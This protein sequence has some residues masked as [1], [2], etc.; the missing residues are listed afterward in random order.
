[1]V[2]SSYDAGGRRGW[3]IRLRS[4][5]GAFPS[6]HR[7]ASRPM[8]IAAWGQ[9]YAVILGNVLGGDFREVDPDCLLGA[10]AGL[11]HVLHYPV[12]HSAFLLVGPSVPAS[13][14]MTQALFR[15]F[16]LDPVAAL[17]NRNDPE[18]RRYVSGT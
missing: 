1:M 8:R 16:F 9:Q 14:Y 13:G 15:W 10:A 18:W 6:R 17:C 7:V 2:G 12:E 3:T 4:K 5:I 11:V